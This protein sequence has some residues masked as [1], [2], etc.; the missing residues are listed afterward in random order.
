MAKTVKGTSGKDKITVKTNKV[1]VTAL[2]GNDTITVAKR[3]KSIIYGGD[4]NDSVILKKGNG[5]PIYGDNK[6][7]KNYTGF[8]WGLNPERNDKIDIRNGNNNRVYGGAGDDRIS[9]RN[10]KN[11]KVYGGAGN[12]T[13]YVKAG[14]A[15]NRYY[16]DKGDDNLYGNKNADYL[17]G[18]NGDDLLKGA[19]GNDT[20]AGG[21]GDD[22]L[23]G[24]KGQDGFWY[25]A[26]NDTVFDYEEGTDTIRIKGTAVNSVEAAGKDTVLN[27]KN[28]GT[29]TVKNMAGKELTYVDAKKQQQSVVSVSTPLSVMHSFMRS[30]SEYSFTEPTVAKALNAAVNYASA[31]RFKSLK[32]L[33]NSFFNTIKK[34]GSQTQGDYSSPEMDPNTV[35]FLEKYMGINLSNEDTGAITGKDAGGERIK[36]RDS[37]VPEAGT[38]ENIKDINEETSQIGGLVFHWAKPANKK[39]RIIQN[40]IYTWWA[41]EGLKLIKESYGLDFNRK[42]TMVK[43]IYVHFSGKKNQGLAA[44]VITSYDKTGKTMALNMTINTD[45]VRINDVN[46]VSKS[47]E[48]YTDEIVAHELTHAVMAANIKNFSKLP[49]YIKEGAAELTIGIDKEYETE[50]GWAAGA[51]DE[52]ESMKTDMQ[53]TDAIYTEAYYG[54]YMLLRYFA[55][56][57]SEYINRISAPASVSPSAASA[58]SSINNSLLSFDEKGLTYSA[59]ASGPAENNSVSP[60]ILS[61]FDYTTSPVTVSQKSNFSL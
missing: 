44:Y 9:V 33:F 53:K 54:G 19:G 56:Q 18:G 35:E 37:V 12:D 27:F 11:N 59:P 23:Y 16:G 32:S 38:I 20:L 46:G 15:S 14:H 26:G 45:G 13:I 47:T 34:H 58:V 10:G 1:I 7:D 3:D 21:K 6:K 17:S 5:T 2:E 29:L 55:K 8:L 49:S 40:C 42:E 48:F 39:E 24:G 43:D 50:I 28:G 60:L 57:S 30:L 25:S 51:T 4:G 22:K 36:T 52:S 31:G 41:K 61:T